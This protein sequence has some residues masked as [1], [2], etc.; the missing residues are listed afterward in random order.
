MDVD[1]S[2]MAKQSQM[3]VLQSRMVSS[4]DFD[5]INGVFGENRIE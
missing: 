4:Q 3:S 5:T 1:S 2:R